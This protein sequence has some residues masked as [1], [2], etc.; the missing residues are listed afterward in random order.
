M[1]KILISIFSA[2]LLG[3]ISLPASA[4]AQ[5][6]P[7]SNEIWYTATEKLAETAG[8]G[9]TSGLHYEVFTDADGKTLT[10]QSHTWEEA[11]GKGVITFDGGIATVGEN[12]FRS[13]KVLSSI[14]IPA[15]VTNIGNSAFYMCCDIFNKTGLTTVTF[16]EGSKLETIGEQ[17]FYY[18][19]LSSIT[20][21]ASVTS[22]GKSAFCYCSSL[23]TVTFAEGSQL[24]TIGES[25]FSGCSVLSSPITIPASVTSI[26]KS[27]FS[28]CSLTTVTFAEGSQLGTIRESAFSGCKVL[29]TI[30]IPAS[31][32]SI[33]KSAFQNCYDS[34]KETGLAE[35]IFA[36]GSQLGTIGY[37]AFYNCK[38]LS[39]ITIPAS[40]TSIGESAFH[41]CYNSKNTTGLA[42]VTFAD[43]SKLETIG[44]SAFYGCEALS[45][46]TIPASVTSIG[47]SA[48][49]QCEVLSSPITI[50]ASVTSIGT[51]AFSE[52]SSL[53]TVTFAEGSQLGTIGQQAFLNCKVLSSITIPAS[54]TSIGSAAFANC[55]GIKSVIVNWTDKIVEINPNVFSNCS[56]DWT[57]LVPAGTEDLYAAAPGWSSFKDHMKPYITITANQDPNN[58]KDYYATF[59]S[60]SKAYKLSTEDVTAYTGAVDGSVLKLKPI[61]DGIIPA[62]EGVVLK[63][64]S[65]DDTEAKVNILVE[66]LTEAGTKDTENVL[67]GTDTAIDSAPA[68]T[69]AFSLGE[70]G[71]GFY[72]WTEKPI[73]AHKAYIPAATQE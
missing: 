8:T 71:V 14:T 53:T 28:G 18:C 48:F 24:E 29:S 23:T 25:A 19:M 17:A 2:L 32:T 47:T 56:E 55:S 3:G 58:K 27:A 73:G 16:A 37:M 11:T 43:G 20:I 9:T 63:L 15:S 10:M 36:E 57:L 66:E 4:Q 22:I 40:V 68:G 61:A 12:A 1:K 65:T 38:A 64:T 54:V 35:V 62:G 13:C 69:K 72:L 51:S 33:E 31:V 5:T 42:E 41:N 7:A 70:S 26:G 50:P 39:S 52:C 60:S 46:I 45:S 6:G 49:Q 34:S 30:T 59:Y 21:P 44:K 67:T